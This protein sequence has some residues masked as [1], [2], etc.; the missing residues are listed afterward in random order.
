MFAKDV[1]D[2]RAAGL[3]FKPNPKTDVGVSGDQAYEWGTFAVTDKSGATVDKGKYLTVYK[4]EDGKWLIVHDTW[5]SDM[6][7]QAGTSK[8]E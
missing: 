8:A 1:A 4:K 3:S 7:A 6:P 5:N 2:S